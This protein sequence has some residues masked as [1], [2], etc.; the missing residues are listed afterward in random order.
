MPSHLS[1]EQFTRYLADQEKSKQEEAAAKIH[2][3]QERERKKQQ[4]E[5]A[6][7]RKQRER[8]AK[9]QKVAAERETKKERA[10]KKS[11]KKMTSET[12]YDEDVCQ[13]CM[14]PEGDEEQWVQ[15][16]NPNCQGW[17][18]LACTNI[19]QEDY[20]CLD[21]I[22]WLCSNMFKFLVLYS[23]NSIHSC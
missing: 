22:N 7:V 10:A 12:A 8:E 13:S 20:E 9:K 11:T 15:C 23:T 2:R 21:A 5:A 6:K 16:D 1:G 18:H 17:Y 14:Q 3:Q 4:P 19:P